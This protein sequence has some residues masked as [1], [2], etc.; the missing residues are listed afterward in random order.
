MDFKIV[1]VFVLILL[2]TGCQKSRY[3]RGVIFDPGDYR[4]DKKLDLKI[5]SENGVLK[6]TIFSNGKERVASNDR[7][8]SSYQGWGFFVDEDK[9]IWVFS[10][11]IG[12]C[13][14]NFNARTETYTQEWFNRKLYPHEVPAAIQKSPLKKYL[15]R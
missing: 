6:Y 5:T 9:N 11:D 8:I 1:Y 2:L 13:R 12:S 3:V 14:W 7:V 15:K 10:S 4:I